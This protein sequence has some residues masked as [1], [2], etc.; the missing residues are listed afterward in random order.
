[1]KERLRAL[2]ITA[3]AQDPERTFEVGFRAAQGGATG[4]V[5]RL[6]RATARE[7]FE[8]ARRLRP[9][10]RREGCVLLVHDRVDVA[11]AADADGVHLGARSLPVAAAKRVAAPGMIVGRSVHNL[12]QA[13]QIESEGAAAEG[14]D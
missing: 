2:F 7:V 14:G 12:D 8:V 6:P 4:I 5:V 9:P 11:I 13:G 3:P 10:T 1:M